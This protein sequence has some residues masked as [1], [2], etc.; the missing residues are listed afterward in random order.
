MKTRKIRNLATVFCSVFMSFSIAS[1]QQPKTV[2]DFYLALP[3]GTYDLRPKGEGDSYLFRESDNI[4]GKAAIST[5]RKSLIKTED[6]ANGYLKLQSI[7]WEGGWV[8]IALFK[9]TDKSYIVAVSQVE[10]G[11]GCSGEVNFLTYANGKWIDVSGQVSPKLSREEG[12]ATSEGCYFILPRVGRT[13]KMSCGDSGDDKD[14]VKAKEFSF[15]WNGTSFVRPVS[16]TPPETVVKSLYSIDEKTGIIQMDKSALSKYFS[17]ELAGLIFKGVRA[18]GCGDIL[19]TE[20]RVVSKFRISRI[21][22]QTR[23]RS[24]VQVNYS[25]G[26]LG[27]YQVTFNIEDLIELSNQGGSWKIVEIT[28]KGYDDPDGKTKLSDS[29]KKCI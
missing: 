15:E 8:E 16:S 14:K 5:F 4:K 6:V 7:D 10:C 24:F 12:E 27:N 18:E 1:A 19:H 23:D 20:G 29:L 26:T 3:S 22:P 13:L 11:P 28:S 25:I 21:P 17:E 9:K 2:T